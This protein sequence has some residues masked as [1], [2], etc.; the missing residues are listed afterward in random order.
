MYG[1]E[2]TYALNDDYELD[3]E[4]VSAFFKRN[5]NK[6]IFVFGFTFM[7]WKYF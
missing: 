7:V 6:Q 5:K 3:L 1:K 4:N 2:I